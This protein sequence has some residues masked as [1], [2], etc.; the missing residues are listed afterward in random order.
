MKKLLILPLLALAL[1]GCNEGTKTDVPMFLTSENKVINAYHREVKE[2]CYD[3]VVY[4][5]FNEG[6]NSA[7]G[8]IKF[9]KDGQVVTCSYVSSGEALEQLR[10]SE[11]A[12]N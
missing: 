10:R 8:S 6:W 12:A 4:V 1:A 3:G 5:V 2:L 11:K 7:F 9:N